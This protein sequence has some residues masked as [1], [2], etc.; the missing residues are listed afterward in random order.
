MSKIMLFRRAQN[1]R[2]FTAGTTIFTQGEPGDVMYVITA[3][4][5]DIFVDGEHLATRAEGETIGEMGFL[6]GRPRSATAVARTACTLVPIDQRNFQFLLDHTPHFAAQVLRL[7]AERLR[8]QL[9][10]GNA[11]PDQADAVQDPSAAPELDKPSIGLHST[12]IAHSFTHPDGGLAA[13][14]VT[15]L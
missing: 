5:V 2:S 12:L 4:Q 15:I 13:Q 3:G 10:V 9:P 11:A 8:E 6:D 14:W 7:L 1:R